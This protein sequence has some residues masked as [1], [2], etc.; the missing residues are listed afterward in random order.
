MDTTT[1]H[2]STASKRRMS[3]PGR[4]PRL[5]LLFAVLLMAASAARIEAI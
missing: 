3:H 5:T 1:N 2:E 4:G